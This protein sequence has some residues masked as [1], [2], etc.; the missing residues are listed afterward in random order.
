[1]V[2]LYLIL[3]ALQIVDA[4]HL[5]VQIP[6]VWYIYPHSAKFYEVTVGKYTVRPMDKSWDSSI[7]A[8]VGKE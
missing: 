8:S 6:A 2:Y 3:P 4:E 5:P 7:G 1:M